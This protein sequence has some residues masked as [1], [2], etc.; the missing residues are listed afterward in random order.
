MKNVIYTNKQTNKWI[1]Q[2]QQHETN[3]KT[4]KVNL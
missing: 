2:Q 1:G 3:M 4:R